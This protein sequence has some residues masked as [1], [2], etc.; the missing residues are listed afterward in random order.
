MTEV[1]EA[2]RALY[3]PVAEAAWFENLN[4]PR[5]WAGHGKASPAAVIA[6]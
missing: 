2:V 3:W 4:T 6:L 1:L 5:D